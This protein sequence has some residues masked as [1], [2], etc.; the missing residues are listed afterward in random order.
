MHKVHGVAL[1]R[2]RRTT[3]SSLA[4]LF[5]LSSRDSEVSNTCAIPH[6]PGYPFPGNILSLDVPT[7]GYHGLAQKYASIYQLNLLGRKVIFVSSY[8]LVNELS[9]DSRF[10]KSVGGALK[11]TRNLIHDG[12]FT[13]FDGESS[14]ITAHRLLIPVFGVMRVRDMLEDMREICDQMICKWDGPACRLNN[15]AQYYSSML[16]VIQAGFIR[17][18]G[19]HQPDVEKMSKIAHS[20]SQ[21]ARMSDNSIIDNLL[22]F[23]IAALTSEFGFLAEVPALGTMSILGDQPAQLGDLTR[24]EYLHAVI[25]ESKR[26]QPTAAIRAVY[27]LKNT[28]IGDGKYFIVKDTPIA[29]QIWDL[30]RDVSVL[31]LDNSNPSGCLRETLNRCR[32]MHGNLYEIS[33]GFGMRSCIGRAFAWQEV[34]I[35]YQEMCIVLSSIVQRF[36][37][38]LANPLY[39][40]QITQAI[41]IKPKGF[42]GG[43]RIGGTANFQFSQ[44]PFVNLRYC[45]IPCRKYRRK[46][47][48]SSS[49]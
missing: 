8:T 25:R 24:M 6:P 40:L 19:K 22:T 4:E 42:R 37:L 9:D 36:D 34:R 27:P 11:E 33:F 13:A 38:A 21:R 41:T 43:V 16:H 45:L 7:H 14:W 28:V 47:F 30:H 18:Y 39:E 15:T 17:K 46:C 3:L 29:L 32:P 35:S 26:L 31:G 23:L 1:I 2:V 44:P 20:I 5:S 10:Q 48:S 49:G 12:I